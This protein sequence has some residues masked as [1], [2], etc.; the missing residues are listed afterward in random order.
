[1][2][3]L[4]EPVQ[5]CRAWIA[6]LNGGKSPPGLA[7]KSLLIYAPGRQQAE[8]FLNELV[9]AMQ[10]GIPPLIP[11]SVGWKEAEKEKQP[12][13]PVRAGIQCVLN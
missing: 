7:N 5:N 3:S 13:G 11:A 8:Q 12:D 4:E 6:S 10:P 1:L 9:G 2:L